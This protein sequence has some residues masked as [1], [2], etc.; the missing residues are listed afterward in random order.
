MIIPYQQLDSETL[1]ALLDEI[2]SRD[3]TDYGAVEMSRADKTAQLLSQL[4]AQQ[5]FISFDAAS[6]SCSVIS[7][8]DADALAGEI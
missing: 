3:G 8:E 5:V 2:V 4:K 6:D 1:F 7:R